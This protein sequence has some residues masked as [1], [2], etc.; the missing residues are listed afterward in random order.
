VYAALRAGGSPAAEG[1]PQY[2]FQAF[3][4]LMGFDWIAEFDTRYAPG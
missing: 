2:E 4:Q 1:V 3:S